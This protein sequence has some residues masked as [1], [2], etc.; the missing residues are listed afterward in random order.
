[1]PYPLLILFLLTL[2][3]TAQADDDFPLAKP[4]PVTPA[5]APP[6]DSP[7]PTTRGYV[8]DGEEPE[9]Q[10]RII[11]RGDAMVEEY[12]INGRL[13]MVHI[14]PRWGIPYYLVDTNGDGS[15]DM[16]SNDLDSISTPMWVIYSW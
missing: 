9:P 5:P 2:G 14:I 1:M 11:D 16:R 3:S 13:Y 7:A 4:P 6:T 8:P 12:R 10:V 15:Y